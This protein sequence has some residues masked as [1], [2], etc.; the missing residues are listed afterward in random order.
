MI[1]HVTML[2]RREHFIFVI[3]QSNCVSNQ[4]WTAGLMRLHLGALLI[5]IRLPLS[6]TSCVDFVA[7]QFL[8]PFITRLQQPPSS[9]C[10]DDS[11]TPDHLIGSLPSWWLTRTII[12]IRKA[13]H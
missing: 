1:L 6:V 12:I 2:Q 8:P 5:S 7:T 11:S 10:D 4:N 13:F 9:E 3:L